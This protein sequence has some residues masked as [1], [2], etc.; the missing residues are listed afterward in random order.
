MKGE[1]NPLFGKSHS[2]ETIE[3]MRNVKK[4]NKHPLFGKAC[5]EETKYKLS[6]S[7][8]TAVE[9]MN[10]MTGE[11][12]L[13][14]SGKAASIALSCSS[15]TVLS[16]LASGKLYKGIYKLTKQEKGTNEP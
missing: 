10:T 12:K 8:G 14:T 13:Y 1:N 11:I 3:K 5:S 2:I 7:N 9:I 15:A 4:G 16:Y 6:A